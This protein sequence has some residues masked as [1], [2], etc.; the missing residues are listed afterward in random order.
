MDSA[1]VVL[2]AAYHVPRV[3]VHTREREL[4]QRGWDGEWEA[5]ARNSLPIVPAV[6]AVGGF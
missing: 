4:H 2:R 3:E 5:L 1:D 6:C